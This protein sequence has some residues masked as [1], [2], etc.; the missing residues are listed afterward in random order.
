MQDGKG[1]K[2][3]VENPGTQRERERGRKKLVGPEGW[4]KKKVS[5]V[6]GINVGMEEKKTG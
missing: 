2:Y 1:C 5:L 6:W 4:K 3:G